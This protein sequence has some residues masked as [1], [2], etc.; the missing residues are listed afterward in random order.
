[1]DKIANNEWT[2]ETL[3]EFLLGKLESAET[4]NKARFEAAKEAVDKAEEANNKRFEAT[5]E[6]RSSLNDIT[7]N[8]ITRDEHNTV[9]D[10]I[11]ELTARFETLSTIVNKQETFNAQNREQKNWGVQM[12]IMAIGVVLSIGMALMTILPRLL[13]SSV[14]TPPPVVYV[15]PQ[16]QTSN[17]VP[18]HL[19]SFN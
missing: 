15:Q 13:S 14:T 12:F 18:H 11:A 7:R 17:S 9:L 8:L 3:R 2:V 16:P 5:N 10:R 19:N 4:L 1:M 6:W